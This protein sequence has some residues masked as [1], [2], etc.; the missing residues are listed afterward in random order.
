[1]VANKFLEE[2]ELEDHVRTETV[3]M[4]KFFHESVRRISEK[5]EKYSIFSTSKYPT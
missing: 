3:H 2:V 1:M 5:C 4:C